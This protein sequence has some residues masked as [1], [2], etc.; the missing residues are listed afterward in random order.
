SQNY[1]NTWRGRH[2]V[3]GDRYTPARGRRLGD[4]AM[5]FRPLLH[6][7]S[8]ETGETR[9]TSAVLRSRSVDRDR[10][11]GQRFQ[12]RWSWWVMVES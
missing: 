1:Y 4:D 9:R 7:G 5:L 3:L 8:G 6:V 11:R 12:I 2:C 10:E